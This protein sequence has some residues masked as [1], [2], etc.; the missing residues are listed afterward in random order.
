MVYVR[1]CVPPPQV[2]L[3]ALQSEKLPTQL[4]G[5]GCVLHCCVSV[6]P[7]AVVQLVPPYRAG[8]VTVNVFVCV[9]PPHAA[10]QALQ[11][12]K[13]PTQLI[14]GMATQL[15]APSVELKPYGQPMQVAEEPLLYAPD[16]HCNRQAGWMPTSTQLPQPGWHTAGYNQAGAGV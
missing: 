16:G 7:L 13:L 9:P 8:C 1:V 15:L 5:Q 6:V 14:G 12:E 2:A 11:S 3:Q 4:M 10:L